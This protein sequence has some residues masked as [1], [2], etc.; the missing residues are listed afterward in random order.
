[1]AKVITVRSMLQNERD[2]FAVNIGGFDT[3][4]DVHEVLQEKF[5]EMDQALKSFVAEMK[6]QGIWGNV[7][8]GDT[9]IRMQSHSTPPLFVTFAFVCVVGGAVGAFRPLPLHR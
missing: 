9:A 1:M 8:T 2:V 3:H 6:K 5:G 4:S 7:A